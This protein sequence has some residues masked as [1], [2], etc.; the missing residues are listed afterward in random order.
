MPPAGS[1]PA[2]PCRQGREIAVRVLPSLSHVARSGVSERSPTL[3]GSRQ[4]SCPCPL[5]VPLPTQ[6]PFPRRALPRVPG[7]TG[8][9]ATPPARPVPRGV[10]VAVCT[11]PAG[12]P[13]LPRIPSSTRA[14]ATTP[15]ET[16]RLSRRSLPGRSA[17]FPFLAEGRLP[18]LMFRGLLSVHSRF[19]PRGRWAS[20]RL[21]SSLGRLHRFRLRARLG[22]RV[23]CKALLPE[24]FSSC[25]YLHAPLWLLP[26]GATVAGWDSH[27][28]GTRAF[29]RRTQESLYALSDR[30]VIRQC[31]VAPCGDGKGRAGADRPPV[32][33]SNRTPQVHDRPSR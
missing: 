31:L 20:Y 15:A 5:S 4:W 2:I 19:G 24:C 17:A 18:R 10:P 16:S 13:V 26:A 25:R 30:V 28:Q 8:P 3:L 27:P 21:S 6:G 1:P 29:P 11:A 12:L 9:S 7:T 22:Y 14:D 32:W 33:R 23:S